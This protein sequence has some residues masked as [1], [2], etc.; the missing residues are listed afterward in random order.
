[1]ED[2]RNKTVADFVIQN[3]NTAPI[4]NKYGIDFCYSGEVSI[5]KACSK[6]GVDYHQLENELNDLQNKTNF[7]NDFN[8]W[9]L[10]FL[11]IFIVHIHHRYVKKNIPLLKK[12]AEK[13]TKSQGEEFKKLLEINQLITQFSKG[14]T[15]H[16]IK[17]ET[18]VFPFI[19][20]LLKANKESTSILFSN[21]NPINNPIVMMEQYHNEAGD[22]LKKI[23]KLTNKYKAPENA[24]KPFKKLCKKLKEFESNL[25]KHVHLENNILFPKAKKL[26][27]KILEY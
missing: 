15:I 4:F 24:S 18:I 2:T 27:L 8:R 26:E 6:C 1:M 11:M 14:L 23:S 17:E 12:Y 7:L 19:K 16:M 25:N 20:K 10:D 22:I 21:L 5:E 9:G 3:I 13:A